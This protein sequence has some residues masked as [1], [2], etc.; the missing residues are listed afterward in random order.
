MAP[1]TYTGVFDEI[2]ELFSA[3]EVPVAFLTKQTNKLQLTNLIKTGISSLIAKP[4]DAESLEK[5]LPPLIA[6]RLQLAEI[7]N[8]MEQCHVSDAALVN[9]KGIKQSGGFR[10]SSIYSIK[11]SPEVTYIFAA[12]ENLQGSV[13]GQ[14]DD[15]PLSLAASIKVYSLINDTWHKIWPTFWD[16]KIQNP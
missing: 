7:R 5:K 2:R 1:A 16:I 14:K 15:N 6:K 13:R 3:A 10:P 12:E 8:M 4:V 9:L 11:Y